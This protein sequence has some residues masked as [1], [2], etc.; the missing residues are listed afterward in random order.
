[1][2]EIKEGVEKRIAQIDEDL[3]TIKDLIRIE[4]DS[5]RPHTS[6]STAYLTS[7]QLSRSKLTQER[8]ELKKKVIQ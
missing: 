6:S 8:A 7:L 3:T 1:M 2:T 4:L 5:D